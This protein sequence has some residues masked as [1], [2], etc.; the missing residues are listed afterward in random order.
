MMGGERSGATRG[1][2]PGESGCQAPTDDI[3]GDASRAPPQAAK[4]TALRRRLVAALDAQPTAMRA[5]P[6]ITKGECYH[7]SNQAR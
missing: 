6:A 5:L 2:V 1:G 4:P 7:T 3:D